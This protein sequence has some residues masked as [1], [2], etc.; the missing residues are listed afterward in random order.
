MRRK[1]GCRDEEEGWEGQRPA[2]FSK[3]AT[4]PSNEEGAKEGATHKEADAA[5][6]GAE[7]ARRLCVTPLLEGDVEVERCRD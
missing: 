1:E 6:Q 4:V 3:Q 5:G 7:H 2:S